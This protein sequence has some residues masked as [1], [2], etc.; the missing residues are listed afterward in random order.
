M[1]LPS[2]QRVEHTVT[3]ANVNGVHVVFG[4]EI[5][6]VSDK[7]VDTMNH[8]AMESSIEWFD[9]VHLTATSAKHLLIQLQEIVGG[10]E[11]NFGVIPQDLPQTPRP[12]VVVDNGPKV[13]E[14]NPGSQVNVNPSERPEDPPERERRPTWIDGLLRSRV[15]YGPEAQSDHRPQSDGRPQSE[16]EPSPLEP[17]KPPAA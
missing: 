1:K 7:P 16:P 4:R 5:V 15:Q 11:R 14:F 2:G 9:A 13:V 6:T 3:Q 10:Y 12:A 17:T 8:Y